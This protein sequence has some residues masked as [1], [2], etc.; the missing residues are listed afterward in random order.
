M[1]LFRD[2]IILFIISIPVLYLCSRLKIPA[3]VGLLATGIA[4]GPHS[5]GLVGSAAEVETLAE[6]GVIL[7]LFTIGMEFSLQKLLAI[8]KSVLLGGAVQVFATIAAVLVAGILAGVPAGTVIFYGFIVSLSSTAIVLKLFQEGGAM[9]GPVGRTSLGIL[10]FQDIIVV[11]FM[12]VTPMLAGGGA[13]RPGA[14]PV[15]LLKS[16][17][18][19]AAVYAGSKWIVPFLLLRITRTRSREL[20]LLSVMAICFGVAWGTHALGL[21]LSLGAF[22]AGLTISETEYSHEATGNIIPFKDVF[23]GIFFVSIGMLLDVRVLGGH[24]P[25]ILAIVLA[26]VA[27]K[28]M[29]G[30]LAGFVLG[31]PAPLCAAA[32][33]A[34]CQIGEFSFILLRTGRGAG[35]V[36]PDVYQ[37]LLASIILTMVAAPFLI[38]VSDGAAEI[39]RRLPL[40]GFL[41]HGIL[42][43]P[44]AAA[45]E[46]APQDHLIIVGFGVNGRNVARTALSAGIR[47]VIIEMNP[48]TVRSQRGAGEPIIYGD[49]SSREILELAGIAGAKIIVLTIPDPAAVQRATVLSKR[50]NPSVYVIA[51]TRFIQEVERLYRLGADDVIPEEFETSIEIFMRV[52]RKYLVPQN[53]IDHFI[54]LVRSDGYRMLRKR[55]GGSP[56]SLSDVI[57]R[58]RELDF[59]TFRVEEG[60]E[61]D[62]KSLAQ[63]DMRRRFGAAAVAIYRGDEAVYNPD[64]DETLQGGD[65]VL[66]LGRE[67]AIADTVTVLRR[68]P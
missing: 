53:D 56:P 4:V 35:L 30:F 66:L 16:V 28:T 19:I 21:S 14:V 48:D 13:M 18:I 38:R 47:Y 8:R 41:K 25:A 17:L 49:A 6:I 31:M 32:G 54:D 67:A 60:S 59:I 22:L 65:I 55:A 44:V 24:L 50:L 68:G 52:L 37:M 20:F 1:D 40:P 9:D 10:I 23:T 33:L 15:L 64:G 2:I 26:V 36:E 34:L 39:I 43:S 3:I 46:E 62:G 45:P 61:A 27:L 11:P 51:R 7:L 63:L 29:T 58:F 12:L 57:G 42:G 5:L